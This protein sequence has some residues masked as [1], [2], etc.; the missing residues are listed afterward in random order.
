MPFDSI[1]TSTLEKMDPFDLKKKKTSEKMEQHKWSIVQLI[2]RLKLI[3]SSEVERKNN[4]VSLVIQK[5]ILLVISVQMKKNY[6]CRPQSRQI[7]KDND[8][9]KQNNG[10]I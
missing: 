2:L 6:F 1:V 8:E 3:M 4:R 7:H 5:L 9:I 10:F